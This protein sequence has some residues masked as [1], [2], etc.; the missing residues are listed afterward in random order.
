MSAIRLARAL[1]RPQVHHQV[2][3]LLSRPRRRPAGEGRLRRGDLRHSRLGRRAG[4]DRALHARAALQRPRG[5]GGRLRRAAAARSPRSSWSRWPATWAASLPQPGYLAALR[6]LTEREG[7]LLI[8]DEVMTGFRVA[9][10]GAQE[11]YGITPDLTC[12]G[13][14]HRRRPALRRIRRP[15][16]HHGSARAARP[17]LPGRNA[18][19]KSA[20][21]GRRHRDARTSRRTIA[22]RSTAISNRPAACFAEGVAATFGE[23]RHSGHDQSRRRDV[24]VVLYASRPSSTSRQRATSDTAAF[25]LFHRAMMDAGVWLPPSQFEAIFLGTA[26]TRRGY[27]GNAAAPPARRSLRCM[28]RSRPADRSE[29]QKAGF[30]H[31]EKT[32]SFSSLR[33]RGAISDLRVSFGQ[34]VWIAEIANRSTATVSKSSGM[35]KAFCAF[36]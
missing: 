18:Q 32:N 14:D 13:Q 7:A 11:L 22:Q 23:R 19:R 4:R 21:H 9:H 6:E 27:R 5:S 12:A 1:H 20:G 2:R 33:W 3:G 17:R 34:T 31:S 15:R 36:S 8:F 28:R 35:L 26:H 10:G 30:S 24:D 29:R 25:G 16:R